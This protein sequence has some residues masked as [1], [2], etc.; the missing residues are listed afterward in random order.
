MINDGKELREKNPTPELC[1]KN[2]NLGL[3]AV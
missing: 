3:T 1:L 2:E